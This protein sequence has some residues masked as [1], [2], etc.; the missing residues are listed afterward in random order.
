MSWDVLQRGNSCVHLLSHH[1]TAECCKGQCIVQ[2]SFNQVMSLQLY[3]DEVAQAEGVAAAA[4]MLVVDKHSSV[5]MT[6]CLCRA[7]CSWNPCHGMILSTCISMWP[8]QD[9]KL[10]HV[11]A[12]CKAPAIQ[13]IIDAWPK[14]SVRNGSGVVRQVDILIT[15]GGH[16]T[17][18]AV[19]KQLNDKERVAAALENPS[20]VQ[21]VNN[22]LQG[23]KS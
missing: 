22:S 10:L 11:Q 9:V 20:L 17:E 15:P 5:S 18:E 23:P 16:S 8:V 19:N 12:Y 7:Q 14:G 13:D 1:S 6:S 3:V 21:M 2:I 4:A